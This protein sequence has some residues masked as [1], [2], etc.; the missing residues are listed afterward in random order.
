MIYLAGKSRF[1]TLKRDL[2]I[3]LVATCH[4]FRVIIKILLIF[5][6]I[7]NIGWGKFVHHNYLELNFIF[8]P[9]F[10]LI[11][12]RLLQCFLITSPN[13]LPRTAKEMSELTE[14]VL[15]L[16]MFQRFRERRVLLFETL[17]I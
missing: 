2:L 14:E 16:I 4:L 12:S 1:L 5:G 7:I 10:Y 11:N 13:Q 3:G 9:M 15:L 17:S 6:K 8:V